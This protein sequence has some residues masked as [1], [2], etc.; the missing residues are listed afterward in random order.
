MP[1]TPEA[2]ERAMRVHE[3]I[4]RGLSGELSWLQVADVLGRSPRS[5]RRLR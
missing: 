2:G 5:I 1:V 4:L 3:V